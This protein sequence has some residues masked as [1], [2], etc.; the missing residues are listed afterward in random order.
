[1][2]AL[3]KV[4]THMIDY[5]AGDPKQTQHFVKVHS[6]AALIGRLEGLDDRTQFTLEAQVGQ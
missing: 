2:P 1:M 5:Y 3:D 4:Y 6:F